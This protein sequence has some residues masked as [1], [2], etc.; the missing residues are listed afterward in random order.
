MSWSVATCWFCVWINRNAPLPQKKEAVDDWRGK[1]Q[2]VLGEAG[3]E[4]VGCSAR[5]RRPRSSDLQNEHN[6]TSHVVDV[7][8]QSRREA[9]LARKSI[10][11]LTDSPGDSL[12]FE[13]MR[14]SS[15]TPDSTALHT[16]FLMTM[17]D[18]VQGARHQRPPSRLRDAAVTSCPQL[19][20]DSPTSR[21]HHYF[22]EL[23]ESFAVGN[24]DS[25]SSSC[26]SESP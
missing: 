14:S 7:L 17:R 5:R 20:A 26:V 25:D 24:V 6:S 4:D 18:P 2:A 23:E 21:D 12:D 9:S 16:A 15:S 22:R 19:L 11:H 13:L 8:S 1:F 10:G 3:V